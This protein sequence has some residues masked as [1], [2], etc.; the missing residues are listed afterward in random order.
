MLQLMIQWTANGIKG[1][2][3]TLYKN[4][5]ENNEYLRKT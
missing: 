1:I 5:D 3:Y 4:S 2:K